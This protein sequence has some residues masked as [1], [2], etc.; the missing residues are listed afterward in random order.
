[1]C[2]ILRDL[3]GIAFMGGQSGRRT[4]E[5]RIPFKFRGCNREEIK[6]FTSLYTTITTWCNGILFV[7]G[8]DTSLALKNVIFIYFPVSEPVFEPVFESE[9][10]PVPV[11][12]PVSEPEP[13]VSVEISTSTPIVPS[14]PVII[15][16]QVPGCAASMKSTISGILSNGH[17]ANLGDKLVIAGGVVK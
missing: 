3:A 4:P 10:E 15:P 6:P 7:L 2:D 11:F 12:E 5:N 8:G 13:I 17:P 14:G 16:D 9:A 1:M